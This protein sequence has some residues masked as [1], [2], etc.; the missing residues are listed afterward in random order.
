MKVH[1]EVPIYDSPWGGGNQFIKLL[2]KQFKKNKLFTNAVELADVIFF[3]SHQNINKIISYKK[4]YPKKYFIQRIDG[5]MSYRGVVGHKTDGL[6]YFI[7]KNITDGVIYQSEWSKL[8][9]NIKSNV[10]NNNITVIHNAC[11]TD[12]FYKKS[13]K[14]LGNKINLIASSWSSNFLKGQDIIRYL[15]NSLDFSKYNMTF[16]GN[17]DYNL[18]NINQLPPKNSDSLADIYRKQDLYILTSKYEACSN[19]MLEAISCGLPVLA[20]DCSSNSEVLKNRGELY[21]FTDIHSKISKI[22]SNYKDYF[23]NLYSNNPEN[24]FKLYSDFFHKIL[25]KQPKTANVSNSILYFKYKLNL[26]HHNTQITFN[27]RPIQGPWGGGNQFLLNLIKFLKM[28]GYKINFTL[29]KNTKCIF[30]ANSKSFL[31]SKADRKY[32]KITFGF[33]DLSKFKNK[34]PSVPVIQRINH[35]FSAG[36]INYFNIFSKIS[37][38]TDHYVYISDWTKEMFQNNS[39]WVNKPSIVIQNQADIN[40]FNMNNKKEWNKGDRLKIVTHHFSTDESKGFDKYKELDEIIFSNPELNIE[41][42]YI[43]N[44]PKN[45]K[46]KSSNIISQLHGQKLSDELKK[47]HLYI[48]AAKDEAGGMHWI[49]AIQCG[50]PLLYYKKNGGNIARNGEK[51]GVNLDDG[52]IEGIKIA[53]NNYKKLLDKLRDHTYSFEDKMNSSYNELITKLINEKK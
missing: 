51:Y 1:F 24:I 16:I 45:I 40:L 50:L 34:Y 49:E 25:S 28:N 10:I 48:T 7:N 8:Q 35:V 18:K 14:K 22:E 47:N 23:N 12:I 42:T 20:R 41:F 15:D 30:L 52:I 53:K 38:L 9:N 5:P 43:G 32:N 13:F 17:T 2:I 6:I 29:N 36:D 46:F 33:D 4:K 31:R 11:D 44:L 26:L 37:K 19:S 27:M 3:N 21:Y 39:K